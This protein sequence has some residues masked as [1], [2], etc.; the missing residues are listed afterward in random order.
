MELRAADQNPY[1]AIAIHLHPQWCINRV[2]VQIPNAIT[3]PRNW[4]RPSFQF[5]VSHPQTTIAIK[6]A[7]RLVR[8]V[9]CQPSKAP[10]RAC[11]ML[12]CQTNAP[13]PCSCR[14]WIS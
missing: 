1:Q 14:A 2:Q 8:Q 4:M 3:G 9:A 13:L 5:L 7:T 12:Q 11:K 10:E 6:L